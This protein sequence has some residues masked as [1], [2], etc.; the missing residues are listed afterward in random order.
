VFIG[1]AKL[2]FLQI[3]ALS[4]MAQPCR[5]G[6]PAK[7]DWLAAVRPDSTTLCKRSVK[8]VVRDICQRY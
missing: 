7:R 2:L 4:D 1:R 6:Y 3:E 5:P 8:D